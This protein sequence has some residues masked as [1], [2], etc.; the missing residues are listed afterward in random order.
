MTKIIKLNDPDMN[1]LVI[2]NSSV[3][4]NTSTPVFQNTGTWHEFFTG[5]TLDVSD[6]NMPLTLTPGEYRLYTNRPVVGTQTLA[7][8]SLW[9]MMLF[10]NPTQTET[11]IAYNLPENTTVTIEVFDM[12]GRKMATLAQN[13][14]QAAGIQQIDY[15]TA[16]LPQ[17]TYIV[18]LSANGTQEI[19]KL[20]K[21]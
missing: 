7:L 15:K 8:G 6:V 20:V 18:R 16:D 19:R 1:V 17:G 13:E 2:A 3:A 11:A 4:G 10:P 14:N 5:T 9:S 21:Q 12:L